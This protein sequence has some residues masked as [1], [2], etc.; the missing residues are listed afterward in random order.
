MTNDPRFD[1]SPRQCQCCERTALW[2][3]AGHEAAVDPRNCP[4]CDH[5]YAVALAGGNPWFDRANDSEFFVAPSTL[6]AVVEFAAPSPL[7]R[8]VAIY[9]AAAAPDAP[10]ADVPSLT[11]RAVAALGVE[12]LDRG[13][14]AD[15][16]RVARIVRDECG[17]SL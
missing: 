9:V 11:G 3:T 12:L 17:V 8:R 1:A 2:G 10:D 5:G 4:R 15:A 14:P 13:S 16:D 7:A 6:P